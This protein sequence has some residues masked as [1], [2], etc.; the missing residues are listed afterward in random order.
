MN[1]QH[2]VLR[3]PNLV[4]VRELCVETVRLMPFLLDQVSGDVPVHVH[5]VQQRAQLQIGW[6]LLL[7][8]GGQLF[9]GISVKWHHNETVGTGENAGRI[10]LDQASAELMEHDEV[11]VD[12]RRD[13]DSLRRLN[14][15]HLY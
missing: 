4:H 10:R 11:Q 12:G 6:L 2:F 9:L 8:G 15:A 13:L 5:V 3:H 14:V 1:G 7:V